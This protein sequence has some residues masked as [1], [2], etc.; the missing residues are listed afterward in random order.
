M[1]LSS[2]KRAFKSQ[3]F[4]RI[5]YININLVP[6]RGRF[7]LLVPTKLRKSEA[8]GNLKSES[9]YRFGQKLRLSRLLPAKY[10]GDN[11]QTQIHKK[12]L[13][14]MTG[15][16]QKAHVYSAKSAVFGWRYK[17]KYSNG[18]QILQPQSKKK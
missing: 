1:W 18:F 12:L 5:R 7:G 6:F 11:T 8:D 16:Y 4:E 9:V 2:F 10:A 3:W 13:C 15:K 17:W 14:L